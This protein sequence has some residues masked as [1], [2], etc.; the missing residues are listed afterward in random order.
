MQLKRLGYKIALDDF[1]TGYSSFN[2]LRKMPLRTLKIDKSFI[3][4]IGYSKK[5]QE[6]VRQM[7]DMAHEMG[8]IVIAEGVED[9]QQFEILKNT[10]CDF[11][12]GYYFNRPLCLEQAEALINT[13][14]ISV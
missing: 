8:L 2:Y 9:Q 4:D 13:I 10:S 7:I 11:I 3:D 5:D 14:P 6:L 1:G 12:Q